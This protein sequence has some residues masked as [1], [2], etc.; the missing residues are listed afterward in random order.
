MAL[1][2]SGCSHNSLKQKNQNTMKENENE[3]ITETKSENY[4]AS[5]IDGGME[6]LKDNILYVFRDGALTTIEQLDWGNTGGMPTSYA[7]IY[8]D[9]PKEIIYNGK[10]G[11]RSQSE[12]NIEITLKKTIFNSKYRSKDGWHIKEYEDL[13]PLDIWIKLSE[14]FN[15]GNF[16]KLKSGAS[17]QA[18]D[19]ADFTITVITENGTYSVINYGGDEL[20]EFFK[21]IRHYSLSFYDKAKQ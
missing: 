2:A 14:T 6:Y 12:T 19:G 10:S 17:K 1:I 7:H 9:T 8:S 11:D 3:N 21:L 20:K 5:P 13:T 16:S 15:W 4:V 18:H